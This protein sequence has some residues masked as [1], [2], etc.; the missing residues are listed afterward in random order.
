MTVAALKVAEAPA[1][2]EL[3]SLL[4]EIRDQVDSGECISLITISIHPS[5]EWTNRSAG[6]LRL[7]EVA[8]AL[9]CC[10]HDACEA[11]RP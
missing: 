7:L 1:R 8:G 6:S 5:R 9:S 3:L 4:E 11:M 10:L 2:A